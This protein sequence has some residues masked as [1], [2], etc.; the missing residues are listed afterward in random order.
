MAT[1]SFSFTKSAIA[2]LPV[3]P[4]GRVTYRDTRT[5][6]L[7]LRVGPS[8][9]KSFYWYRKVN[10]RPVRVLVGRFPALTV[11]QARRSCEK[12][13][14]DAADG[15]D[16]MAEKRRAREE[17]TLAD[18][19]GYWMESHAKPH[20]RT[21]EADQ[22]QYDTYLKPWAGRRLSAIS[23]P[24]V[25]RLQLRIA[26]T[27]GRY[28]ANKVLALVRAMFNRAG[29]LGFEGANPTAGIKKF[30]EEKR[31]RFLHAHELKTFFQALAAEPNQTLRDYFAVALFTG[32]RKRRPRRCS[33]P[34][35]CWRGPR[36]AREGAMETSRLNLQFDALRGRF[37]AASDRWPNLESWLLT[38][39][40]TVGPP[41][42]GQIPVDL[43]GHYAITCGR[44]P[45]GDLQFVAVAT[46]GYGSDKATKRFRSGRA[47]MLWLRRNFDRPFG[48][49][50]HVVHDPDETTKC[51]DRFRVLAAEGAGLLDELKGVLSTDTLAWRG[52]TRWQLAVH[53]T[54][55]PNPIT[56]GAYVCEHIRD[57]FLSSAQAIASWQ[58][59]IV[60]EEPKPKRYAAPLCP[61]CGSRARVASTRKDC[62]HVVCLSSKCGH[63]WTVT[64]KN[65]V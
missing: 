61:R 33:R 62:R 34:G 43:I 64:R 24:D 27:R 32:A 15:K 18:L 37:C 12:L 7:I 65:L 40:E 14:A 59:R 8:G 51:N 4:S 23:K 39:P 47:G 36:K 5:P 1:R 21:W 45:D 38:W 31:D 13:S 55:R 63:R 3:A 46:G 25:R 50:P 53:E 35:G 48:R 11:E 10:G 42:K 30:P 9:N 49:D 58:E 54:A 20:K 6:G 60:D 28:I 19:F 17:P 16:P 52:T 26:E 56:Y 29:G 57:I 41:E 2:A 22:R 44:G